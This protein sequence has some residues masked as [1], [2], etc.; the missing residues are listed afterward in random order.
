MT[1]TTRKKLKRLVHPR[2]SMTK[3][4]AR[5]E[6]SGATDLTETPTINPNR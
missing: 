4:E 3:L 5:I 2:S 1:K 6:V